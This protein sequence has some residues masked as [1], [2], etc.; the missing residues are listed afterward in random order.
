MIMVDEVVDKATT[1]L[2]ISYEEPDILTRTM[3]QTTML[4]TTGGAMTSRRWE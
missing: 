4:Q 2:Q 1:N 3:G